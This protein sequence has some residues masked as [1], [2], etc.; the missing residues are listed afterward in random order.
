MNIENIIKAES[1]KLG[2]NLC[3]IT[4]PQQP[5]HFEHFL[6][7]ISK[8]QNASMGYLSREDSLRFR[9]NP[10][11]LWSEC[12]SI[13]ILAKTYTNPLIMQSSTVFDGL[14]ASYAWMDDYHLTIPE[15]L[16]KLVKNVQMKSGRSFSSKFF[17]DSGPILEREFGQMAGLGWI[18]KNT[19]LISQKYG[20]FFLLSE[21]MLNIPLSPDKP[22]EADLCGKCTKCLTSCP[23]GS[24]QPDRSLDAN[25]CISFLTIE[26]KGPIPLELRPKIGNHV[27]GCDI[28]QEVCPWNIHAGKFQI[29]E[30]SINFSLTTKNILED[31]QLTPQEFNQKFKS[32]PIKRAKHRGYLRNLCVVAGN[33]KNSSFVPALCNLLINEHEPLI[34]M[35]A[36]W[37]LGEIAGNESF[38]CLSRQKTQEK[39]TAVINEIQLALENFH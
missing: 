31:L 19:N 24:L 11:A 37:A 30:N 26:N 28:C 39:D 4:L 2:F 9:K 18:G 5:Q 34:R 17:T 33:N 22:F 1:K 10:L 6:H 23:T 25:T 15:T 14:I 20:S 32:S 38:V 7:W 21:I 8:D 36:A 29:S 35:H 3:G 16:E 13:I 27:F 12:K